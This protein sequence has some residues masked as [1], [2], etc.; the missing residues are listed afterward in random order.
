M[1]SAEYAQAALIGEGGRA[2]DLRRHFGGQTRSYTQALY[3]LDCASRR[4]HMSMDAENQASTLCY[5]TTYLLVGFQDE[6]PEL[7]VAI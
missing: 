2:G 6:V 4:I 7:L 5:W 1:R 3:T